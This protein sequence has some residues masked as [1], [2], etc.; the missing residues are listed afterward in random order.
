MHLLKEQASVGLSVW[1]DF[2]FWCCAVFIVDQRISA[3]CNEG[4]LARLLFLLDSGSFFRGAGKQLLRNCFIWTQSTMIAGVYGC[5]AF[6][7]ETLRFV[8]GVN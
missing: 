6:F 2:G 1:L 8:I 4:A 7:I 3:Q 5:S